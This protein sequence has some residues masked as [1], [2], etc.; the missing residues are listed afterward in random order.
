MS[1][2]DPFR[3]LLNCLDSELTQRDV[4]SLK[5][6]CDIPAGK[7]ERINTGWDLF[8]ILMQEDKIGEQLEKMEF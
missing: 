1:S 8:N 6:V 4:D 2:I 7:C 5:H 3:K